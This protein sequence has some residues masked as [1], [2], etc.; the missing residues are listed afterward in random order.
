MSNDKA[1]AIG[2]CF[3][4]IPLWTNEHLRPVW[5]HVASGTITDSHLSKVRAH[6][7]LSMT[8]AVHPRSHNCLSGLLPCGNILGCIGITDS[9]LL[10]HVEWT[11]IS[12]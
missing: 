9:E 12:W 6:N 3:I 11:S 4:I 8:G 2:L 1:Q 5:T 10:H 7:I